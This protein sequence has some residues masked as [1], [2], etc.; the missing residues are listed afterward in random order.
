MKHRIISIAI[1]LM[2]VLQIGSAV[3]QDAN[4]Y[5]FFFTIK[6]F[7][8]ETKDLTVFISKEKLGE[9]KDK[10]ER[11]SA[12]NQMKPK[13]Y[14]IESA[15]ELG[16]IVTKLPS[17]S[18]LLVYNSGVLMK[19]STIMYVLSKCKDK[20]IAV[21]TSSRE[22]SD[23]GALLGLI[24]DD[25]NKVNLVLNLKQNETFQSSFSDA[26]IEQAQFAEVIR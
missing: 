5:Q 10:I 11:A 19:K 9:E 23:L 1:A 17:N 16:K 13:I 7:L 2:F 15:F 14:V 8:P 12:Q 20:N 21:V 25:A 4:A 26:V 22:Y 6:Q 24:K 18:A 3:A